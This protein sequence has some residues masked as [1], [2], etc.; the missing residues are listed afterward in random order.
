MEKN[1][2][3]ENQVKEV[4][5]RLL[6]EQASKVSRQEFSRVQFKIDELQN[7]LNE[8]IKELRKLEDAIPSGLKTVTN[9]RISGISMGLSNSQKMLT[10]LK[11][12][13]RQQKKSVYSQ[14]IEEKKK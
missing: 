1:I 9:G 12:K 5:S 3:S 13:V 6:N 8:T 7:S 14:H 2:I 10:Q 4:L 11:D